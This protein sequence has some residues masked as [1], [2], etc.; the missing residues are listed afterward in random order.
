M[1]DTI[2]QKLK[3]IED[4][5]Q[6]RILHAVESGSRAWGFSAPDSDFDVRFIY[7]RNPE[8]YMRLEKT[9]DVIE[10]QLDKTLDINGWDLQKT[11][12][13]LH[14]SNPTLFEWAN[15]PIVYRTTP[16]WD[17]VAAVLPD[18]FLS[19]HGL[20]HYLSMATGNYRAYL[21][22]DV[23]K[24][25][26]YLYVLRP[27]LA[28]QW[29]LARKTPP[30]VLFSELIKAEADPIL[31]PEIQRLLAIKVTASEH[32]RIPRIEPLNEFIEKILPHLKSVIAALPKSRQNSWDELNKL[33]LRIVQ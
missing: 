11:L 15:A 13:L 12:R 28:C 19:K 29:I 20:Y 9:R 22:A 21:R 33:F 25:K 27:I 14:K 30:P 16:E 1:H 32:E 31:L 8:C 6:V 24:V 17:D 2:I 18:Y 7:V 10:W 4:T 26:K 3:D 23:V 5:H